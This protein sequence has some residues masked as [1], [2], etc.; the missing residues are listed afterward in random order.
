MFHVCADM[1]DENVS[2]CADEPLEVS[3]I[4]VHYICRFVS[5][6]FH[7]IVA[8]YRKMIKSKVATPT[9]G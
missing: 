8:A 2:R 3:E 9:F 7:V 5:R 1:A 4:Q 6:V